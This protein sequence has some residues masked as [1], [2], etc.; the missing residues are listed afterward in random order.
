MVPGLLVLHPGRPDL[1]PDLVPAQV[2]SSIGGKTSVN[3][4][5]ASKRVINIS[6]VSLL[7]VFADYNSA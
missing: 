7:P 5:H 3:F 6:I 4:E 2:Q 1:G